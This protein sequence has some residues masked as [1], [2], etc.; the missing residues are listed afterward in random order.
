MTAKRVLVIVPFPLDGRGVGLRRAQLDRVSLSPEIEFDF[1]PVR[2]GA[3]TA[4]DFH[5][6]MLIDIAIFE[7]GCEA[8]EEGY[9]AVCIDTVSDSGMKA[10]RSVLDIPVIGAGRAAYLFALMLGRR[11][12]IVTFEPW[13][14][15]AHAQ[16][17]EYGLS[18]KC[19][20]VRGIPG[21]SDLSELFEGKEDE[22]FPQFA[23][24]ARQCVRDGA[25]VICL[26]S[27]T[28]YQVADY[29]AASV[30]VPVVN[31]GPLTYK[32]AELMLGLGVSHSHAAY[33]TAPAPKREMVH[34]MLDAAVAHQS[35]P[36]H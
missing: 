2:A 6:S 28:L 13:M 25:D 14:W 12:S 31:P 9:D 15:D 35:R 22:V 27:T 36:A 11:F 33:P 26:H 17:A 18:D 1:R 24:A 32:L 16:L 20:S 4:D 7:A 23:E 29:L 10:L 3:D 19:A 21:S 5:D 8:Q 34:L 30:G